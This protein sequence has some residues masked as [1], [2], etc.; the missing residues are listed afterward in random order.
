MA[1][2]I[3]DGITITDGGKKDVVDPDKIAR[4]KIICRVIDQ[5]GGI[6]K[7]LLKTTAIRVGAT[8]WRVNVYVEVETDSFV[9]TARIEHSV[10]VKE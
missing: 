1:A 6:P 4:G 5:I 3:D 8:A 9:K 2:A 10:Y 7:N